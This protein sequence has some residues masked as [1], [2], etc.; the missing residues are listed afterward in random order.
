MCFVV[1]GCPL[2]VT[3]SRLPLSVIN[4]L[5]SRKS[6]C[7]FTQFCPALSLSGPC[8]QKQFY[9]AARVRVTVH[10]TAAKR[11]IQH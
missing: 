9:V 8:L 2:S 11:Q 10:M 7:P 4:C 6:R 1:T 5:S 3:D